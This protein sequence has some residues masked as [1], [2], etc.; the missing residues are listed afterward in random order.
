V[1]FSIIKKSPG[2]EYCKTRDS[3][4]S[5]LKPVYTEASNPF[6]SK[7]ELLN[8]FL[9]IIKIIFLKG[10]FVLNERFIFFK[11]LMYLYFK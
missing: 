8:C 3:K 7:S 6:L 4:S 9:L 10:E 11:T 2:S 1:K 5:I